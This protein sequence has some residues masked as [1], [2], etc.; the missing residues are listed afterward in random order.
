MAA[1]QLIGVGTAVPEQQYVQMELYEQILQPYFDDQERAR[2]VFA[3][4]GIDTRYL[5]VHPDFYRQERSTQVRNQAY[6]QI[7][8][9]IGEQAIRRC[10]ADAGI[11][12]EAV[13][14][15]IV[16]SC[17]G[18]DTPGL[19][20]ILAG[21]VGMRTNLKRSTILGMGCYAA[22]PGLAR[23]QQSVI[24]APGRT[25]LVLAVEICSLH[26]QPDDRSLENAV[27]SALFG[28]GAAAVLISS[29]AP[30]PGGSHLELVDFETYSDYQ[31]LDRMAFHLTDHGFRMRLSAYVPKILSAK[32]EEFV[33]GMLARHALTRADVA[34]WAVHPG[35]AKIL[36]YTRQRLALAERAL[37]CSY[38]VLRQYGNLSSPT[39]LFILKEIQETARPQPGDY[40][41]LMA[42][43]PGLTLEAGLVR[44][45]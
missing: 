38:A 45:S 27:C 4:A 19:D 16:V 14:D 44:W 42:F 3:N 12:P 23:A 20:L 7:A 43:G 26:F 32:V 13:D 31:T 15:F 30:S 5:A 40:G 10:L 29:K 24:A 28:D 33:E 17:T 11:G 41:V 37:D 36:D 39:I 2:Q 6:M 9:T 22:M 8:R 34:V 1:A 18:I 35:S 21:A 25:A